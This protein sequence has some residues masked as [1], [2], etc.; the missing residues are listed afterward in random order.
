MKTWKNRSVKLL[1]SRKFRVAKTALGEFY[2]R[3]LCRIFGETHSLSIWE[4]K[5]KDF[6][7]KKI[8]ILS[9]LSISSPRDI[10]V[11]KLTILWRQT[12]FLTPVGRA[13]SH[14]QKTTGSIL[15]RIGLGWGKRHVP[16]SLSIIIT[17][18]SHSSD[19]LIAP[20][21]FSMAAIF[22]MIW[23]NGEE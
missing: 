3:F 16:I 4:G 7:P 19:C 2:C 14:F 20:T 12:L 17:N 8:E 1:K 22:R 13:K 5:S 23:G 11:P 21:S 10:H 9:Y 18:C 6:F 15:T